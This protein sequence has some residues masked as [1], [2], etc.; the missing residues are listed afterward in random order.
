M[1][2]GTT[3]AA[4]VGMT[5]A[6]VVILA[7][8]A[9]G[10]AAADFAAGLEAFD[11]GDFAAV[12]EAW[13]PLAEAGDAEAQTALGG[14]YLTGSG[15]PA[16]AVEAARWFRLAAEQGDPVAQLNL[17]D[18]YATGRGVAPDLV[19]A[20]LWLSLAAA[21]GRSWPARRRREIR[22]AMTAAQRAEAERLIEA[23]RARP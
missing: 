23:R 15:V 22:P 1:T 12:L 4:R 16:D 18:L 5:L 13:R 11:G 19:Q 17:G 3:A 14:L 20:Y 8:L 2:R 10:P 21:Q 6:A 9:W 7:P